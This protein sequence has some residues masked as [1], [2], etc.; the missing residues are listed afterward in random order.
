MSELTEEREVILG[1][2]THLDVHV[3]VLIEPPRDFR[4][5]HILRGWSHGHI[6]AVF[7]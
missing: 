7:T 5:L 4:R 3:A 6:E 1:V 2:D